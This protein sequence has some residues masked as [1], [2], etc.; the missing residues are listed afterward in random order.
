MTPKSSRGKCPAPASS[1]YNQDRFPKEECAQRL[2]MFKSR[3]VVLERKV[4]TRGLGASEFI[5]WLNYRH[6]HILSNMENEVFVA[7]VKE[8]YC[9][10]H[11]VIPDGFTHL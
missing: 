2:N 11:H 10:M 6:L 8:F 9:N 7:W 5:G 3:T 4:E 1:S